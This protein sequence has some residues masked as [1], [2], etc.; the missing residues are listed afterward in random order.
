MHSSLPA[1]PEFIA[2]LC[3]TKP[4]LVSKINIVPPKEL[5]NN[6]KVFNLIWKSL[7]GVL[8]S[9]IFLKKVDFLK[10]KGDN[11]IKLVVLDNNKDEFKWPIF[12]NT[13][14]RRNIFL[15]YFTTRNFLFDVVSRLIWFTRKLYELGNICWKYRT[16]TCTS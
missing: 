14:T 6:F 2:S 7:D 13:Y 4:L 15:L 16:R 9:L 5:F 10:K 12:I 3:V 11:F 8:I 1:I